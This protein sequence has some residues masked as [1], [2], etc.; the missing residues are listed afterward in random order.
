MIEYKKASLTFRIL[1]KLHLINDVER[2]GSLNPFY[3]RDSFVPY[4]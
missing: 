1:N 2:Y 3:W 4:T